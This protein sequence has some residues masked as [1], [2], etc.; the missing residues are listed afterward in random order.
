MTGGHRIRLIKMGFVLL[1]AFVALSMS[2]GA[3]VSLR[4]PDFARIAEGD[5]ATNG[6]AQ[7]YIHRERFARQAI[8][9]G[10]L[11]FHHDFAADERSGCNGIPCKGRHRDATRGGPD[12]RFEAG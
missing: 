6:T 10:R 1:C 7:F 11:L 2:G 8:Q 3:Q 12:S 9:L 4:E 5:P